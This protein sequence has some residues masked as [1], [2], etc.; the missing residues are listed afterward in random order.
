MEAVD[1]PS[2]LHA[3]FVRL[4]VGKEE[5]VYTFCNAAAPIVVDGITFSNLGALLSVGE[6]QQE[7]KATSSDMTIALTG[8]DPANIAIILS[9]EIKGSIVEVWR[10]F[11]DANNQI[12]TSPSTQFFK[13]YQGIINSVAITEDFSIEARTRIATCVISC[14][15]MRQVLLNRLSGVKTNLNSWQ[16]I[17]PDDLSMSR[18]SEITATYFDFGAP[19]QMATQS[20][21][22]SDMP[23]PNI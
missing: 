7:M 18:V 15:S 5:T 23:N 14:S 13:R 1:S 20:A 16:Y 21:N 3:E 9:N 2:I 12:L 17:Y 22:F 8:I 10:G 4:T 19:L 6:I 11:F